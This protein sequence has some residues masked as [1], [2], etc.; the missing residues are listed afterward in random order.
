MVILPSTFAV[1]VSP[2][3]FTSLALTTSKMISGYFAASSHCPLCRCCCI[4][5]FGTRIDGVATTIFPRTAP[6]FAGSNVTF[7]V[8]PEAL[9]LIVSTGAS[10]LNETLFTPLGSLKSN[11]SGEAPKM[12]ASAMKRIKVRDLY[13]MSC[14]L[15][16]SVESDQRTTKEHGGTDPGKREQVNSRHK[17][18]FA[19]RIFQAGHEIELPVIDTRFRP[20]A[21]GAKQGPARQTA[22]S[23]AQGHNAQRSSHS[24]G[25]QIKHSGRAQPDPLLHW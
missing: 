8:I 19:D 21:I 12:P 1:V 25:G 9:P 13:F 15:L 24:E 4:F 7:P 18:I 23:D 2:S 6:G 22:N 5:G 17:T 20:A 14:C 16:S 10:V 11:S 3:V